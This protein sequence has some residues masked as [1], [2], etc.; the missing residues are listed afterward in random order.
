MVNFVLGKL[1]L[2]KVGQSREFWVNKT[3]I[4]RPGVT[5]TKKYY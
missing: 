5:E 3:K 4:Q 2:N 1:R